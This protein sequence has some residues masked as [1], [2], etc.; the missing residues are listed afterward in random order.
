MRGGLRLLTEREEE[1]DW[2][3]LRTTRA[4]P[5]R[6]LAGFLDRPRDAVGIVVRG[7]PRCA[8]NDLRIEPSFEEELSGIVLAAGERREEMN[9][10]RLLP[11]LTRGLFRDAPQLREP[12]LT[13]RD[14]DLSSFPPGRR[15]H[16]LPESHGVRRWAKKRTRW[17][18]R[19]SMIA[20]GAPRRHFVVREGAV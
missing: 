20:L 7:D 15:Y 17:C 19:C 10:R 1:V 6:E 9:R 13:A 8:E 3:G 18:S 14:R 5:A 2:T 12:R 11:T 4:R 16:G